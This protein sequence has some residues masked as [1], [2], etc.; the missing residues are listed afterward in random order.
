MEVAEG[1]E[2]FA[3]DTVELGCGGGFD[4]GAVAAELEL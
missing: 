3:L 1:V 4:L 2:G